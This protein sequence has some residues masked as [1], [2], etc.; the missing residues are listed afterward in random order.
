[1]KIGSTDESSMAEVIMR[2]FAGNRFR[3]QQAPLETESP[4]KVSVEATTAL[5][6]SC[7]KLVE[8]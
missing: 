4:M 7:L 6:R 2:P 5:Q 1:M 3:V 8:K